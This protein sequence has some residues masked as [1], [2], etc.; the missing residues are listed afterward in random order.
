MGVA[1]VGIVVKG[2]ARSV[3]VNLQPDPVGR[4][5]FERRLQF[6]LIEFR[7][8]KSDAGPGAG[9]GRVTRR[10][11]VAVGDEAQLKIAGWN[12]FESHQSAER[13]MINP[14]FGGREYS[15]RQVHGVSGVGFFHL[16][17]DRDPNRREANVFLDVEKGGRRFDVIVTDPLLETL[18]IP[19][20]FIWKKKKIGLMKFE[21]V[22]TWIG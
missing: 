4:L 12:R 5:Q 21:F 7:P 18:K 8:G 2:D 3:G 20:Q 14:R 19:A 15:A 17:R 1:P 6:D 13:E 11:P 16:E 9:F 10:D 22:I